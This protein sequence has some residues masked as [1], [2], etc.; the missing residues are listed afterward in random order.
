MPQLRLYEE[1]Q[2]SR[3]LSTCPTG[4]YALANVPELQG[5]PYLASQPAVSGPKIS[6][7][8]AMMQNGTWDWT[9]KAI[10]YNGNVI[11]DGHHRYLTARL[12]GIEPVMIACDSPVHRTFTWS[13]LYVDA[14]RWP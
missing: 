7:M 4:R 2:Q 8:M 9:D 6:S 1:L 10:K 14:K 11:A 5:D 3:M 13:S 12:S